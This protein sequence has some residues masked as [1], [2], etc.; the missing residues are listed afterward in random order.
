MMSTRDKAKGKWR[1]ILISLGVD[2]AFLTG[3]HGP[4]PCCGGK[5]RFRFDDK[6]QMGN[7]ICGQCGSGD[8]FELLM[9]VKGYGF[10]EAAAEVDTIVG[11]V[12]PEKARPR[13][14]PAIALRK[15]G[16]GLE[17]L[18]GKDPVSLYLKR[19]GL[20]GITGYALRH[21]PALDYFDGRTFL[22]RYHAMVAKIVNVDGKTES[23]HT[24][25]LTAEGQK[26][27]V[28]ST[29]K[30]KPPINSIAGGAI[31]L[32][33]L[34]EHI[35]ITEGIENALAVMEGEGL[36]CWACVSASGIETFQAP[37]G[38][39]HV[40]V[41]CDHD[42]SFTGQKAAYVLAHRLHRDGVRVDVTICGDQ[43]EDYLDCINRLKAR[44]A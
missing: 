31:R 27:D 35:A 23:F 43:G 12:T 7:W 21:H 39:R 19:R 3:K 25:Y 16:N 17:R 41:F 9:G 37:E 6:L 40:S 44:A 2:Q 26:A 11:S 22:G 8:G 14:D 34:A 32:A 36:P 20:S 5:D 1:G 28:P 13:R 30:I 10:R 24:T 29:K 33:P 18:T 42:S 4:C 15:I 38:V